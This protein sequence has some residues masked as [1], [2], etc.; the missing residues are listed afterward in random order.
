MLCCCKAWSTSHDWNQGCSCHYAGQNFS[1]FQIRTSCFLVGKELEV[2]SVFRTLVDTVQ[3]EMTFRLMPRNAANRIIA[4][5]TSQQ[6]PVAVVA[7]FGILDE[8]QH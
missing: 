1:P 3:A 8:S 4:P 5:L 6:A 7:V 2:Q